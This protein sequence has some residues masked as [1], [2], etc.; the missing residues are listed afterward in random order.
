MAP[1]NSVAAR[2]SSCLAGRRPIRR[3]IGTSGAGQYWKQESGPLWRICRRSTG[4]PLVAR[5]AEQK[6]KQRRQSGER[7]RAIKEWR[8]E[9]ERRRSAASTM[10][11]RQRLIAATD[12]TR[13]RAQTF[14][15]TPNAAILKRSGQ[16]GPYNMTPPAVPGSIF[17]PGPEGRGDGRELPQRRWRRSGLRHPGGLCLVAAPARGASAGRHAEPQDRC[18]AGARRTPMPFA[19][20][21]EPRRQLRRCRERPRETL[22]ADR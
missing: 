21:P 4:L 12:A 20:L 2:H 6:A 5:F 17:F 15:A 8:R 18:L 13:N 22:A 7:L 10:P 16:G 11:P 3:P 1:E 9:M 14:G 19:E